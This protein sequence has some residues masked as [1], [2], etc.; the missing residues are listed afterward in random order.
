MLP[1]SECAAPDLNALLNAE[2][3]EPAPQPWALDQP[4]V[5]VLCVHCERPFLASSFAAHPSKP[6]EP[7]Q[8]C[9]C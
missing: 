9:E 6:V 3:Q 4:E 5:Y 8:P 1:V 2:R 7:P